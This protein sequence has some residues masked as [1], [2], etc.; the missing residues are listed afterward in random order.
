[1]KTSLQPGLALKRRIT[2][3]RARTIGFMEEEG[4]VYATP[5]MVMDVEYT[6]RD[7]LLAH[8]DPGEDSVGVRVEIDHLAA[9]PVDA[10]VEITATIAAV[11]RRRVTFEFSVRDAIDEAG[12]GRHIRFVSDTAKTKERVAA[13]RAKLPAS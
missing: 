4:R 6:C 2:V 13:K 7:L 12:R 11:D 5:A 10:W 9:T 1:M 8:L 3:D